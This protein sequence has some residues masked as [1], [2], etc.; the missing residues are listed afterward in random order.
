MS[1]PDRQ[2]AVA[3]LGRR[4]YAGDADATR[5]IAELASHAEPWRR[6]LAALAH[7]AACDGGALRDATRDPSRWVRSRAWSGLLAV[8]TDEQIAAAIQAIQDTR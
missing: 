6:W 3:A 5:S 2:R 1:H 4:A 7:R 8:G